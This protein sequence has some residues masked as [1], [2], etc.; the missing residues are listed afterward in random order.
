[1]R[2]ILA[3]HPADLQQKLEALLRNCVKETNLLKK[4]FSN[5]FHGQE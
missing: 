1:M 4:K 5:P 3:A 2:E